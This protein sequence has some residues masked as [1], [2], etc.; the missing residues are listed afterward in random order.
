MIIKI[1]GI[2]QPND[3]E[4]AIAQGANWIGI[5]QH[6]ASVRYVTLPQAKQIAAVTREAGGTPVAVFVDSSAHDIL[7]FCEQTGVTHVQLHG[8]LSRQQHHLLPNYLVRIY[9]RNILQNGVC[10][11]DKD[12][13][14]Q[15]LESSRD[16]V[17]FDGV[18]AGSGHC[19]AWDLLNPEDHTSLRFLLAGGLSA[20]NV[21]Q[22]IVKLNPDGVDVSSAVESIRGVKSQ[23]LIKDFILSVRQMIHEQ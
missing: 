7:Q 9:V 4:F 16:Y 22:A 20:E 8:K 6:P 11:P 12:L 19:Y 23:P 18:Q 14:Q 3:A 15:Y 13:G 21:Q 1:C 10:L 17:M 2:T 5:L